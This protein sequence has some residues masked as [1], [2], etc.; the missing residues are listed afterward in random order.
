MYAVADNYE[1]TKYFTH[2]PLSKNIPKPDVVAS[3]KKYLAA[4]IPSMFGFWG[5]SAMWRS[6]RAPSRGERSAG[7]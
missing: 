2:D 1:A 3:V 7:G 6:S 5:Y 4:G